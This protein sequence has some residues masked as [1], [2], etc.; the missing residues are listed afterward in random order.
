MR[1]QDQFEVDPVRIE[2][3]VDIG[4]RLYPV[5]VNI[6]GIRLFRAK[7]PVNIDLPNACIPKRKPPL[8]GDLSATNGVAAKKPSCLVISF[9]VA[10]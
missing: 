4:I 9:R 5:A 2:P 3:V 1:R 7:A 10:L 6:T 8:F